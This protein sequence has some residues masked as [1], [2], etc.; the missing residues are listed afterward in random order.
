MA[1]VDPSGRDLDG[2]S[3]LA[4]PEHESERSLFWRAAYGDYR[5]AAVRRGRWK[6]QVDHRYPFASPTVYLFDVTADPGE[7]IDHYHSHKAVAE[8][9][10]A[11]LSAWHSQFPAPW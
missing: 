3:L 7:S 5:Q 11:E 6:L 4:A 9:L 8:E 10:R 1:G 2:R